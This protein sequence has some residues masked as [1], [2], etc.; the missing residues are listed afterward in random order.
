MF[1][2][3]YIIFKIWRIKSQIEDISSDSN[4]YLISLM[5]ANIRYQIS[6]KDIEKLYSD[7]LKIQTE[8]KKDLVKELK[9]LKNILD[10]L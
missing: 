3:L 10:N 2:R 8:R 5:S 1:R 7:Y 6:E 4:Y 9:N